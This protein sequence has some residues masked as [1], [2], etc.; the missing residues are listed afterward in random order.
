MPGKFFL[1][2]SLLTAANLYGQ[3]F[4]VLRDLPYASA[5]SAQKLDLLLPNAPS[6]KPFPLVVFI[7]GGGWKSG[8]K[9]TT[10]SMLQRVMGSNYAGATLNYRLTGEA[11]WPAQIHDV[12]AALRWLH[13]HGREY[14]Y[15]PDRMAVWGTSAG[16][17]LAA[18]LGT[19]N[20]VEALEGAEGEH[21]AESSSV[22]CAVSFF[23]PTDLLSMPLYPSGTDHTASDSPESR[24][25]GGPIPDLPERA[26]EA[27]PSTWVDAED[28]P[29][30]IAHG[31]KDTSVPYQQS[32]LLTRKLR[33]VGVSTHFVKVIG[34][35]HNLPQDELY[36]RLRAFLA[37]QF[38][39]ATGAIEQRPIPSETDADGDGMSDD[40]ESQY[41]LRSDDPADGHQDKDGDGWNNRGEYEAG[42]DPRNPASG[43]PIQIEVSGANTIGLRW[44]AQTWHFYR[45]EGSLDLSEWSPVLF[46]QF[47]TSNTALEVE[48]PF[49]S[50]TGSFYYR[51]AVE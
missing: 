12:K 32:V 49:L 36:A 7:H 39:G 31:D 15:N 33:E 19:T 34:A 20:G 1:F 25:L 28:V 21:T 37:W 5:S 27:S 11:I 40:W 3:G 44:P 45:V 13:A 24:L 43:L 50:L 30:F 6:Q 22:S 17:H 47:R 9:S 41:G 4:T 16:G 2:L 29:F 42:T 18:M 35:G 10:Q 38:E 26:R 48:V 51:V 14:G 23:G 46:N 8:D